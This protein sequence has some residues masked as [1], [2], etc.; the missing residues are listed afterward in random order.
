MVPEN[1]VP[2]AGPRA[3]VLPPRQTFATC[4]GFVLLLLQTFPVCDDLVGQTIGFCRLSSFPGLKMRD[5]PQKRWSVPGG[6]CNR[7]VKWCLLE[8][9][10][11]IAVS[12][13]LLFLCIPLL[14]QDAR[15]LRHSD[16]DQNTPLDVRES[17]VD[18]RGNV[19]I[20][21]LSYASPKGGRVPVYL[22]VP[23]GKGLFAAVIYCTSRAC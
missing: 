22:M 10:V 13:V 1:C 2:E 21:D 3:Y 8:R 14:A 9:F 18:R 19:A 7:G 15:M 17:G 11:R 16:Y 5:R 12:A 20:H 6:M 23:S 4:D